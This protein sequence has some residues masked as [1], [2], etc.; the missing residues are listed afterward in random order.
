MSYTHHNLLLWNAIFTILS[1]H[2]TSSSTRKC[3]MIY[4]SFNKTIFNNVLH[5]SAKLDLV[6]LKDLMYPRTANVT[7]FYC[8]IRQTKCTQLDVMYRMHHI[9][10]QTSKDMTIYCLWKETVVSTSLLTLPYPYTTQSV[11][12]TIVFIAVYCCWFI[13]VRIAN[14]DNDIKFFLCRNFFSAINWI[15]FSLCYSE[16][17]FW[18]VFT[19]KKLELNHRHFHD[20]YF[21]P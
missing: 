6:V 10:D 3:S 21:L 18:A 9:F 14:H 12:Q 15:L 19:E 4:T 8:W 11:N 13:V 2:S 1:K 17:L 5:T 7:N 16:H 20:Y